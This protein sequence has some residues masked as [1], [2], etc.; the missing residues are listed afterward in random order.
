[1]DTVIEDPQAA[2]GRDALGEKVFQAILGVWDIFS[3][4]LGDR[5]GLYAALAAVEPATPGELA[6]ATGTAERY[7]REW[8]EQQTVSGILACENPHAAAA[9]RRFVFPAGHAAALTERDDP[10][11]I[12]PFAQITVGALEPIGALLDA[13]RSGTGVP[14]EA[15]GADLRDGQAGANR[16]LFLRQLGGEYLRRSPTSTPGCGPT[17]RRASPTRLRPRLVERRLRPGLSERP[18]RRV[19]P[20]RSV[21]G[22]GA[23]GDRRGGRR[24][25]GGDFAPD[26]A[27]PAL[28]GRYDLV[29]A[30]ECVHDMSDPV[31]VLR[32]MRRWP[33]PAARS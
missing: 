31:G 12:A 4:H 25:P 27:D 9:D 28:A 29:T 3:I 20:R 23:G 17:L 22:R 26:A 30:F 21:G 15:Y 33:A 13:F 24:R 19:R 18:G 8:L 14:Y 7:V 6:A 32:T 1:M 10:G 16:N 2:A 11:F 5:L